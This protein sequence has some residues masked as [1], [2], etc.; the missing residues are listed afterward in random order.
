M[1]VFTGGLY[2]FSC[3]PGSAIS[4]IQAALV[5]VCVYVCVYVHVNA[6]LLC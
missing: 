3:H 4:L 2:V 1:C 6:A 5:H